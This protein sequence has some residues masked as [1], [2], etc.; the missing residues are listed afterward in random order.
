MVGY[1]V[2][3]GS[4][5]STDATARRESLTSDAQPS[6]KAQKIEKIQG[7]ISKMVPRRGLSDPCPLFLKSKRNFCAA[8]IDV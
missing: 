2:F 8:P 4:V 3:P 1:P 7:A 5:A 6:E